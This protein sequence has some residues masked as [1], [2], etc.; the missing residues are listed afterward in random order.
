MPN[1]LLSSVVTRALMRAKNLNLYFKF[2]AY[3]NRDRLFEY[4][5]NVIRSDVLTLFLNDWPSFRTTEDVCLISPT[6]QITY[7]CEVFF[8]Q[9][10]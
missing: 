7:L 5:W 10:W 8:K 3:Q 9:C 2:I 4:Y 1:H 6:D